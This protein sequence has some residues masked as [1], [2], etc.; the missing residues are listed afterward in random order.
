MWLVQFNGC[1]NSIQTNKRNQKPTTSGGARKRGGMCSRYMYMW[2]V[3]LDTKVEYLR[4]ERAKT[5]TG[6]GWSSFTPRLWITQFVAIEASPHSISKN[7]KWEATSVVSRSPFRR[8]A[9]PLSCGAKQSLYI[10]WLASKHLLTSLRTVLL[11]VILKE[12]CFSKAVDCSPGSNGHRPWWLVLG[13]SL[14]LTLA[15]EAVI[16]Q[17]D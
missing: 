14:S 5:N 7:F 1:A 13:Y 9:A 8:T 4:S 12:L 6:L 16:E 15:V 10:S 2:G 11:V 3:R 17:V